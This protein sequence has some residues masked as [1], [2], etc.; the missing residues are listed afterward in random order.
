MND[1]YGIPPKLSQTI[2][3]AQMELRGTFRDSLRVGVK[4]GHL[5][6]DAKAVC[7]HGDFGKWLAAGF[8]GT[9]RHAQRCMELARKYPTPED[10]PNLSLREA[11]RLLSGTTKH[12]Q[13][14][15]RHERLSRDTVHD[16]LDRLPKLVDAV[17]CG[18]VQPLEMEGIT[19]HH[20]AM[21]SAKKINFAIR[22][23]ADY[24][25]AEFMEEDRDPQP[26]DLENALVFMDLCWP[27]TITALDETYRR[28]AKV[29]HPDAGGSNDQFVTLTRAYEIIN[30]AITDH[31]PARA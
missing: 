22:R 4:L 1:C 11:L 13:Q 24:L 23:L 18:I 20:A 31:E 12:E 7:R 8:E 5:L 10:V 9:A 14:H 28:L 15:F 26:T 17:K 19:D 29:C 3:I 30:A 21:K 16:L 27:C 2:F 6:I 25:R